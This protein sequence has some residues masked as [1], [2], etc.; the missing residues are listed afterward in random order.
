MYHGGSASSDSKAETYGDDCSQEP[1]KSSSRIN[2]LNRKD[3][4]VVISNGS[5]AKAVNN[6]RTVLA[7][8]TPHKRAIRCHSRKDTPQRTAGQMEQTQPASSKNG[9]QFLML[10]GNDRESASKTLFFYRPLLQTRTFRQ[11]GQS[12]SSTVLCF[13]D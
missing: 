3:G 7:C 8:F 13:A 1:F 4:D 10:A 6:F 11:E 12:P 9:P 2:F 5:L